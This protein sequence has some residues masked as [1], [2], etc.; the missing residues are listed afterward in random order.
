LKEGLYVTRSDN[1]RF[2]ITL[3]G[4]DLSES[5]SETRADI[6]KIASRVA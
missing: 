6:L 1:G 2:A 5:L 3:K 4:V